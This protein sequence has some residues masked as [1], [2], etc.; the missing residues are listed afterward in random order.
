[1]KTRTLTIAG[2]AAILVVGGG[3]LL[4][5]SRLGGE[6]EPPRTAPPGAPASAPVPG[7]QAPG[8]LPALDAGGTPPAAGTG[9]AAAAGFHPA[10]GPGSGSVPAQAAPPAGPRKAELGVALGAAKARVLACAGVDP[11]AVDAASDAVM[12]TEARRRHPAVFLQLVPGKDE[13][14]VTSVKA[15]DRAA[16]ESPLVRCARAELE[17]RR[18]EAGGYRPGKPI[19]HRLNLDPAQR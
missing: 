12:P 11:G 8:A 9:S 1:M 15:V 5:L 7:D 10:A 18:F 16:E 2:L 3:A 19:R 4:I 6:V 14:T 13:V 17:G